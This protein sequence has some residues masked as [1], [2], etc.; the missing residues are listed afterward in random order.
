MKR[1][2]WALVLS[3]ATM[4]CSEPPAAPTIDAP[5][6]EV[7]PDGLRRTGY[8]PSVARRI[9]SF[10]RLLASAL[11]SPGA[12]AS[13]HEALRLSPLTEHKVL[14][15]EFLASPEG[16]PVVAALATAASLS[17]TEVRDLAA[18]LPAIDLY[19]PVRTHRQ[20]WRADEAVGVVALVDE[21]SPLVAHRS[22]GP[23]L[24][25]DRRAREPQVT[26]AVLLLGPHEAA[27][28]RADAFM[29][30]A[31]STSVIEDIRETGIARQECWE[32]CG[33][34]GGGGGGGGSPPP[35]NNLRLAQI[36][37][38]G[39]CD[40][41]N[42]SEGNEFE[43][44]GRDNNGT[45]YPRLRCA[46]V[47]STGTYL[48]YPGHCDAGGVVHTS[49][50]SEVPYVDVWADET[51]GWNGDDQFRTPGPAGAP[52]TYRITNNAQGF[53]FADLWHWDGG[54]WG[55]GDFY[56]GSAVL[57]ACDVQVRLKLVW[58]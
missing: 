31:R 14:L 55:C 19:V 18:S 4:G 27:V 39:V 6:M 9:D 54:H 17:E 29:V 56:S 46:D 38:S 13:V 40:N 35:P 2:H 45:E 30:F 16:Q 7:T 28:D 49:S 50:P 24:A 48:V 1:W 21:V 23:P 41:G 25:I 42:C 58:P 53:A 32:E 15:A 3:A 5:P 33:G 34:S 57:P 10:A 8:R 52:S 12:R 47:P 43:V 20:T 36:T 11:A 22:A 37:T 26:L 51:D 44:R